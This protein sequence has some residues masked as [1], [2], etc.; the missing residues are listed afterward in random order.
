ML[1]ASPSQL[2]SLIDLLVEAVACEFEQRSATSPQQMAGDGREREAISK[3][4]EG[5]ANAAHHRL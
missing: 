3:V 4:L 1:K 5:S 2:D